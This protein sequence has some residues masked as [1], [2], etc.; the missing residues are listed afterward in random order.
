MKV[1]KKNELASILFNIFEETRSLFS[2]DTTPMVE[3]ELAICS[4]LVLESILLVPRNLGWVDLQVWRS[5][6]EDSVGSC[7][8]FKVWKGSRR[9]RTAWPRQILLRIRFRGIQASKEMLWHGESLGDGGCLLYCSQFIYEE[10]LRE[11]CDIGRTLAHFSLHIVR[12]IANRASSSCD[13]G[14]TSSCSSSP[15]PLDLLTIAISPTH[16]DCIACTETK[17][18]LIPPRIVRS[19]LVVNLEPTSSALQVIVLFSNVFFSS[20]ART[21][22]LS[23][24]TSIVVL[25]T[26]SIAPHEVHIPCAIHILCYVCPQSGVT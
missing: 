11:T 1:K 3:F 2:T 4:G 24:V 15:G 5:N 26:I 22:R 6:G 21:P 19:S 23:R 13:F 18:L 16:Q 8:I 9:A 20:G 12:S 7:A 25:L 10:A 17:T 14:Y